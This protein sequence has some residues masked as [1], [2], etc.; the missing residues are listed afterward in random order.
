VIRVAPDGAC[1]VGFTAQVLLQPTFVDVQ[2]ELRYLPQDPFAVSLRVLPGPVADVDGWRVAAFKEFAVH[3]RLSR[4]VL[5][6]G[7][8][9][10]DVVG[11][12]RVTRLDSLGMVVVELMPG[13]FAA[14]VLRLPGS[15]VD[16]FLRTTYRAVPPGGES[17]AVDSLVREL[18]GRG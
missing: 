6:G 11:D 7:H 10:D 3:W 13:S 4:E 1:S 15:L 17:A 18:L 5:A 14:A 16:E 2:A 8:A 9:L 12:V